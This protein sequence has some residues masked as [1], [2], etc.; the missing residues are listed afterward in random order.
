MNKI[1][2]LRKIA[3]ALVCAA[4]AAVFAYLFC[5]ALLR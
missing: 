3:D 4:I 1:D 2:R 5:A